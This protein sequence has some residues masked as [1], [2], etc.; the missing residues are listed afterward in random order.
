MGER[1]KAF[2]GIVHGVVQGVA[3]RYY[4]REMARSLDLKG[5]V[6]NLPNGTVELM[7]EGDED[8][9]EM[10]RA[11]LDRGPATARV[12]RVDLTWREPTGSASSFKIV[13]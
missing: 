7:A 8:S 13:Y 3:F 9:I 2:H 6:R 12:D 10:M 1:K 4:T 5:F 11:W